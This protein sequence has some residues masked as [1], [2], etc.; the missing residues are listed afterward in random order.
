MK[1]NYIGTTFFFLLMSVTSCRLGNMETARVRIKQAG[2]SAIRDTAFTSGTLPKEIS[3]ID[4][5]GN[6]QIFTAVEYDS[7]SKQ[8]MSVVQLSEVTVVARSRNVAERNGKVNLDFIITVPGELINDKWQ[9][10]LQ[11][12]AYKPKETIELDKIL[13]SG[14]DFAKMQ[15][16]GYLQ[17][18][19]FINSIIPDSLYL[20][21]MFDR[22]GYKAA[23]A[24]LEAE[25]YEAWK[26][27]VTTQNKWIDWRD[28]MNVRFRH[29]NRIMEMNR[30][31]I[32]GTNTLLSILPAY[33]MRRDLTN[34]Y[35][36][37]KWQLFSEESYQLTRRNI[38]PEDSVRISRQFTDYKR[39]AENNRKK[40]MKQQMFEKLVKVPYEAARLD[41]VIRKGN[42][43]E[44]YYS[45]ELP[46]TDDTKKIDLTLNGK[47]VSKDGNRTDLP[48]SDT[49]TYYISSMVQFLD[50]TPRYKKKIITR[51][52][53][54]NL[55]AYIAFEQGKSNVDSLLGNNR[56]EIRKIDE[57]IHRINW[58]GELL[59][60]SI[61]MTATASP[62]GDSKK[63]FNLS[64]ERAL[65]FKDFLVKRSGDKEGI[66]SLFRARWIGED[67][68]K[69][70]TLLQKDAA[71]RDRE[72]V[73]HV[74]DTH[75]SHEQKEAK[76]KSCIDYDYIVE[77]YYPQLRAIDFAFHVHR[78]DMLQDT[79]V[80][81]VPDEV[82]M[83]ALKD[84]KARRY[85]QAL[86]VL[87]HGYAD[88]YNLGICLMS[89]GYDGRAL[90]IMLKQKDTADR[91]YILAIL[92]TRLKRN[93]EA[94]K[95][96]MKACEQDESKIWR[97]KLDPE[98]NELIKTYNLFS[99]EY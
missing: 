11:P 47:I 58:T 84:I 61:R 4:D 64:R 13:L 56:E 51:K 70:R 99:N 94:V 88:D 21:E 7:L 35:I 1:R 85:K 78:R 28:R 98:I 32:Q 14:S 15:K 86:Q 2:A 30:R 50:H 48:P 52:D 57:M 76:I 19:A 41:T 31:S 91:N 17:Y 23:M 68:N 6:R 5:K 10:Q 42:S 97:G 69:L 95:Y 77:T 83:Q 36:P 44:Y 40:E 9:L 38:T 74:F 53:E 55:T 87:D 89:L 12:V 92:F 79:I 29:F 63:N 80:M 75:L 25:Y 20:K 16:Q 66:D 72:S 73:M 81:P 24:D 26:R 71:L 62:E 45:Q 60:D 59:I 93:T 65:S 82:Y 67:W 54:L 8:S 27:D 37:S 33:W 3:Y 22:K 34:R 49:I 18:Q 43:F 39:I 96:L 90:E 46:A